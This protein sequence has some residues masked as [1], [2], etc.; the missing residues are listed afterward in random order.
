[1]PNLIAGLSHP[2]LQNAL[3]GGLIVAVLAAF[4]GYFVVLRGAAFATHALSQIGF[5]GA[6]GAVLLGIEP[7]LGL[8]AF[9]L[10]GAG[11]LGALS[12]RSRSNDVAT[13]LLLVCSLGTGALFLALASNFGSN[14]V[15][16]LFGTIVGVD[17][18]QVALTAL[19]TA[20]AL[21]S[22]AAIARPLLFATVARDAARSSGVPVVALDFA[23]LFI[24]AL[25]AAVT[26]PIVGTL[27]VFSLTI[28]PA[29]AATRVTAQPA[30]A[31]ALSLLL[32]TTSVCIGVA[33]AYETDWPVGFFIAALATFEYVCA[34]AYARA[35]ERRSSLT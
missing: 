13:A 28:G 3:G 23:F 7:L 4:V 29:A 27:L 35:R 18:A 12:L 11:G 31:L 33:L 8:I 1:M 6:A 15:S 14:V 30:A 19:A 2:Y 32:G 9:S 22:L 10:I 16:L 25:A 5:A 24:V 17:R 34:L 20:C 26:V 21:A